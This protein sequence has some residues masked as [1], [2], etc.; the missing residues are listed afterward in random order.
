MTYFLPVF[1]LIWQISPIFR[2]PNNNSIGAVAK[3]K[4][5]KVEI[6]PL[7]IRIWSRVN[8]LDTES[9][10]EL[11]AFLAGMV[12]GTIQQQHRILFPV[13]DLPIQLFAKATQEHLHNGSVSDCMSQRVEQPPIRI[14]CSNKRESWGHLFRHRTSWSTWWCPHAPVV[15]GVI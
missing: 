8:G 14:Q 1:W 9:P 4:K 12:F 6:C 2:L 15:V 11:L 7:T 13:G 5:I 10:E 3:R